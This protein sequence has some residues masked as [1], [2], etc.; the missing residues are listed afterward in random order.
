MS[1]LVW[2][3]VILAVGL[4]LLVAE[5]FIP[6]GGAFGILSVGC[7]AYS[8]W[9]AFRQSTEL[10]VKFLAADLVVIPA[11]GGFALYLWPKTKFAKRIFLRPPDP[12]EIAV[13]HPAERLDHLIGELGRAVTPLRPSGLVD[14]DGR[15]LEGL[16]EYG[17]IA[18][19][20]P[21]RAVRV[22]SGRLIVRAVAEPAG[23]P[24]ATPHDL[25]RDPDDGPARDG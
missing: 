6:S 1:E 14:F 3:L 23:D 15:R 17:L 4:L 22:R 20:S 25:E 10:G 5:V 21:I 2:P 8:L 7:L 13:S 16:S 24:P 12:D 9:L 19:G 18:A 11:A